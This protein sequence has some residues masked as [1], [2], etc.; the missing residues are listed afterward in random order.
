LGSAIVSELSSVYKINN[1]LQTKNA[2]IWVLY[3]NPCPAVL[4]ECGYITNEKDRQFITSTFNQ[5]LIA[6]KLLL[7]ISQYVNM[8]KDHSGFLKSKSLEST[9]TLNPASSKDTSKTDPLLV[10]D[11]NLIGKLSRYK[12]QLNTAAENIR[13]INVVKGSEAIK[14]YGKKGKEGIIEITSKDPSIPVLAKKN[15]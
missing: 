5:K 8:V 14:K 12:T 15:S 9:T 1:D 11:G 6:Q 4:I 3:K 13:S 7:S 10:I 2:G